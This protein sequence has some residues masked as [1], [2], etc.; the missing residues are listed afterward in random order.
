MLN[1]YLSVSGTNEIMVRG[2][3]AYWPVSLSFSKDILYFA[4]ESISGEHFKAHVSLMSAEVY[5][6]YVIYL[7]YR[8]CG[9]CSFKKLIW[10][11]IPLIFCPFC[12]R[13][14]SFIFFLCLSLLYVC[15]YKY[16]YVCKYIF[17]LNHLYTSCFFILKYLI[18]C[19][20]GIETSSYYNHYN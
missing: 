18:V 17:P 16:V 4:G 5:Q 20:L 15:V 19:F 14:C 8:K 2:Q 7:P 13:I 11:Y 12:F 6:I 10:T 9:T 3:L 1:K